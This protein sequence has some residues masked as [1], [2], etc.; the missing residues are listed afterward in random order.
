MIDRATLLGMVAALGLVL[1]VAC[2]AGTDSLAA[3][4]HTS[5]AVMVFGGAV[6]TTL[7]AVPGRK[8]RVLLR[9][10][11][12]AVTARGHDPEELVATLT[13]LAHT[14]RRDGLLAL[15]KPVELLEDD[16]L[17]RALRMAV[18]GADARIIEQVCRTALESTDLRHACGSGLLE[19]MG[20]AAPVFGMMGTLVGLA[21][22]LGR[23]DDPSRIGP[24]VAVALLT[25]LYGLV[26]AHVFCWPLARK[27][28]HRSSEELLYKTIALAGALAIQAGDHPR[29]VEQKL[30]A[31]LP[32]R[33]ETG[34]TANVLETESRRER[35]QWSFRPLAV[36]SR[37][38]QLRPVPK[39]DSG[40]PPAVNGN[41]RPA[42][43]SVAA[44][45]DLVGAAGRS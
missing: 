30:R 34:E 15:E 14:A 17:K 6:F 36:L 18:D 41:K 37:L 35:L 19:S 10:L 28:T 21:T 16:F 7:A 3:L 38:R 31:Y 11:G 32:A 12:S 33:K 27:L 45:Q 5:S 26:L 8:F 42:E 25:T 2:D 44:K 20:R 43:R 29:M 24:G 22:M 40:S 39:T 1:W 9:V 4:W 13:G 23:M